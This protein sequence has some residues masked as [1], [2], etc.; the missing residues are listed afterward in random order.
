MFN[1]TR[2]KNI[3]IYK[4]DARCISHRHNRSSKLIIK[5]LKERLSILLRE[6]SIA[7][8]SSAFLPLINILVQKCTMRLFKYGTGRLYT[9]LKESGIY[10]APVFLV[11]IPEQDKARFAS[12]VRTDLSDYHCPQ[13]MQFALFMGPWTS[14]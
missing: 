6:I 1:H 3:N 7:S 12:M 2:K 4:V 14:L 8:V 9:T 13:S 11:R 5:G 10:A